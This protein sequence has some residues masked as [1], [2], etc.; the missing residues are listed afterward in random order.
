MNEP[1]LSDD[2]LVDRLKE[3]IGSANL[4]NMHVTIWNAVVDDTTVHII[5][6]ITQGAN[7]NSEIA[8]ANDLHNMAA[9]LKQF[10]IGQWK[11]I[12][13]GTCVRKTAIS[14]VPEFK[15]NFLHGLS[16]I[17]LSFSGV[18]KEMLS[19]NPLS[20]KFKEKLSQIFIGR[21]R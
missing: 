2:A 8:D 1:T 10:W 17:G 16:G 13:C 11:L 5:C 14:N 3:Y 19:H 4:T 15:E 6:R 18:P 9:N 20:R 21:K 12:S 7:F